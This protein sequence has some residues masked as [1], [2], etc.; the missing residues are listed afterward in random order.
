[1]SYDPTIAEVGLLFVLTV[2]IAILFHLYPE[3]FSDSNAELKRHVR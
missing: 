2:I 3:F 1:M